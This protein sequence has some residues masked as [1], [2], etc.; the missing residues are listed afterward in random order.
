[1]G[2]S[3]ATVPLGVSLLPLG[4]PKA[5]VPQ[6]IPFS[7][8]VPPSKRPSSVMSPTI[9]SSTFFLLFL[10]T[11]LFTYL[12]TGPILSVLLCLLSHFSFLH[13]LSPAAA[14]LPQAHLSR[15]TESSS[16]CLKVLGMTGCFHRFQSH[17]E[18]AV[19]GTGQFMASVHT[20]TLQPLLQTPAF[21]AQYRA[22]QIKVMYFFFMLHLLCFHSPTDTCMNA[23]FV[24]SLFNN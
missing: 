3:Q 9:S 13:L 7:S 17:L 6:S 18:P 2:P 12:L 11:C 15:G 1:M 21:Y 5:A 16:G 22:L 24:Y 14:T 4:P 23:H 20:G 19:T 8:G 10:Q